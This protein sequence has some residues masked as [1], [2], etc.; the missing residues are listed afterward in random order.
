MWFSNAVVVVVF[1]TSSVFAAEMKSLTT[2]DFYAAPSFGFTSGSYEAGSVDKGDFSAAHYGLRLGFKLGPLLLGG[3]FSMMTPWVSR[4][5]AG[6]TRPSFAAR[7]GGGARSWW[8][9]F[10]ARRW[11]GSSSGGRGIRTHETLLPTSFQDWLHR[12]LGQPSLDISLP[13]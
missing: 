1:L 4:S 6:A 7:S 11:G 3:G 10:V 9:P 8:F 2:F 12:P 13:C 5:S